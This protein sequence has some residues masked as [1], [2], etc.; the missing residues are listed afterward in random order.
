MVIYPSTVEMLTPGLIILHIAAGYMCIYIFRLLFKV[1]EQI[2]RYAGSEEY[3]RLLVSDGLACIAFVAICF[4]FPHGI[5]VVRAIS[6]VASDLL[7]CMAVRLL[8]QLAYQKRVSNSGIGKIFFKILN[9]LTGINFEEEHSENTNKIRVA[10]VGAGRRTI[11]ESK[12]DL[13]T[14]L[15]C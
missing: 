1:Y 10:I 9:A 5:T 14:G 4:I 7:A 15:L 8:Y 12:G 11:T 6:L 3:I 13:Y 2:W